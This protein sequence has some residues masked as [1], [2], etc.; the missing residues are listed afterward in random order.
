MN[1]EELMR[2]WMAALLA[3]ID[4]EVDEKTQERLMEACGTACARYHG[5]IKI[6]RAIGKKS[7]NLDDLLKALNQQKDYWCGEWKRKG[8]TVFSV[9][10]DCGCPLVS[11]GL[12]ELSPSFCECSRGWVRAVFEA[13]LGKPVEVELEQ[14]IG[15]GN[16][17]CRFVVLP[18]KD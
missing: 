2:K 9:C 13:A 12:V 3:D 7:H 10:K 15:R 8:D 16:P 6:A 1:V 11:A 18:E 5:S 4:D 14:S 17:V